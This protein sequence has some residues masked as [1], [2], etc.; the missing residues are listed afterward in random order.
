MSPALEA[1]ASLSSNS[2]I[3]APTKELN[4]RKPEGLGG[5][6]LADGGGSPAATVGVCVPLHAEGLAASR[7]DLH[8]ARA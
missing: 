3:D 2:F 7:Q 5:A 6:Q 1:S 8:A 4:G